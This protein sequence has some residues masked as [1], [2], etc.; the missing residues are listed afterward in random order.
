MKA[1]INVSVPSK[2]K[3]ELDKISKQDQLTR[4]DIVCEALRA[5]FARREFERLRATLVPEAE[6]RGIYTDDD[7]FRQVS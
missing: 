1:T 7:V 4:S 2:I 3:R 5:Y 6:K